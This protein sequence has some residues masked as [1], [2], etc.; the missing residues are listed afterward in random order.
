MPRTAR[1]RPVRHRSGW[2]IRWIDERGNHRTVYGVLRVEVLLHVLA[3]YRLAQ[4][5]VGHLR[6][7][8]RPRLLFLDAHEVL[9][10]EGEVLVEDG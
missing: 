8:H 3:P 5:R 1:P 6:A 9:A 4:L 7:A 10:L 2:R